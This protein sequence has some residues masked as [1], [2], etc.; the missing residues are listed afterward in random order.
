MN[1]WPIAFALAYAGAFARKRGLALGYAAANRLASDP[2]AAHGPR[3]APEPATLLQAIRSGDE[4]LEAT[5]EHNVRELPAAAFVWLIDE[6]DIGA[7]AA[8]DAIAARHPAREIRILVC[9]DAPATQ[10]PKLF[11]L[12]RAEE[13]VRTGI[14]LVVDDDTMLTGDGYEALLAALDTH[15]LSTGL[16]SYES[17]SD[18]P[19]ALV[20][21]FV[22]N[23]AALAY[24]SACALAPPI[25]INGMCYALRRETLAAIGGFGAYVSWL[26]DDLAIANAIRTHGG[27]I[28]Q[29]PYAHVIRTT[30]R[31]FAHYV[32]LMHRWFLF[33]HLLLADVPPRTRASLVANHAVPPLLMW[34]MLAGAALSR[35]RANA[36]V[37]AVLLVFRVMALHDVQRRTF[38]VSRMRPFV[39]LAAELAE[40]LHAA[41][42]M[43]RKTIRW[44]SRTIAVRAAN[45]FS[46][47]DS[48][49]PTTGPTRMRDATE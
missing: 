19:S 45:D 4:H 16:P 29:T 34:A 13:I 25:T 21:Q 9:P 22:D 5:L 32:A 46:I 47:L 38:G 30:V 35:T 44:R 17:G 49:V 43:L 42:A 23:N 14:I 24:L 33:A 20:E 12:A 3:R 28:H 11:K 48:N 41:H 31:D 18:L 8:C 39:S 10:N 40:P 36:L 27:T 26:P 1:V 6:G 37:V 15:A 2:R 7:A